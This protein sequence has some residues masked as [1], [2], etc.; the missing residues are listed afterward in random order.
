VSVQHPFPFECPAIVRSELFGGVQY[1]F[2]F[3][4]G[5][6]SS[7]V[8]HSGSYGVD[9]GLWE[10]AVTDANGRLDYTTPVTDDVLGY[11]TEQQVAQAL[12]AV[13]RLPG[14]VS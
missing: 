4:N 11:L 13:C 5:Y 8:R 14:R 10:L 3:D 12:D 1:R 9:Q 7:V 6:G 2:L